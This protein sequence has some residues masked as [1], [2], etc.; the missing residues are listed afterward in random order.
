MAYHSFTFR[1]MS[2]RIQSKFSMVGVKQNK[3]R[4]ECFQNTK[5]YE[6]ITCESQ[7]FISNFS[8]Y[9]VSKAKFFGVYWLVSFIWIFVH[10]HSQFTGQLFKSSLLYRHV[11]INRVIT[12]E[13]SPLHIASNRTRIEKKLISGR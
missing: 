12:A 13:R 8:G 11:Y 9:C 7:R 4:K 3:S 10:N 1:F 5:L 6:A 2:N